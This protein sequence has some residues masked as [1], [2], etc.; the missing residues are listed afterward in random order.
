MVPTTLDA[1]TVGGSSLMRLAAALGNPSV[2]NDGDIGG[3]VELEAKLSEEILPITADDVSHDASRI[4][5]VGLRIKRPGPDN[6]G[7]VPRRLPCWCRQA[8]FPVAREPNVG[9]TCRPFS[10]PH[11]A[12]HL[13]VVL[14]QPLAVVREFAAAYLAAQA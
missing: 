9:S 6:L 8:P 14:V 2:Q 11:L 12:R 13:L 10:V 7:R 3:V 5:E 1:P 4:S